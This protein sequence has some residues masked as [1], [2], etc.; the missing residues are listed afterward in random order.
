MTVFPSLRLGYI[1]PHL[2]VDM[3]AYQFYQVA[4]EG[5]MLVTS[6]LD[7]ADY[8]RGSVEAI[9]EDLWDRVERLSGARLDWISLS[10]VPLG[11]ALGRA[12]TLDLVAGLRAR[13]GL[14]ASTDIESHIA[15]LHHL[16][17][18]KLALATRW[19][20]DVVDDV[21]TYLSAAD[22]EVVS[23]VSEPRSLATNK[24]A[25]PE[26][27]HRLAMDLGRQAAARA[28]KAQAL[29]LPGGLWFAV[30]AAAALEEE[31]GIPV[32]LNITSTL[33]EA[34]SA[35]P[36]VVDSKSRGSGALLGSLRRHR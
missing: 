5:V 7:L 2:Y 36:D 6:G 17:A 15:A 1:V 21:A 19:P 27:D 11:A 3:D 29:I 8:S 33:W 14:P 13:S 24:R 35:Y 26:D 28:P 34:L 22:I 18:S 32:L 25:L 16:G 12:R 9:L 23:A 20:D 31:L 30:D 4:P 10:G